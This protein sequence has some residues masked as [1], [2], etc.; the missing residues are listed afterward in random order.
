M[1][2]HTGKK[3]AEGCRIRSIECNDS[4]EQPEANK[5][6]VLGRSEE[7]HRNKALEWPGHQAMVGGTTHSHTERTRAE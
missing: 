6:K 5:R 3:Q 2:V 4:Q 7:E 1:G